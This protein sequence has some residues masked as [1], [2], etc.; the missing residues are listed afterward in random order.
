VAE[1]EDAGQREFYNHLHLP[2]CLTMYKPQMSEGG[3]DY[4]HPEVC[5]PDTAEMS[6]DWS[7]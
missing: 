3:A 2:R 4:S 5:F 6:L 1:I 7:I